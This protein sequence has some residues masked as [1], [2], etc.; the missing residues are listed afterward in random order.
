MRSVPLPNPRRTIQQVIMTTS[1]AKP[2]ILIPQDTMEVASTTPTVT[3][4][5]ISMN[6]SN[7]IYT[8]TILNSTMT[9]LIEL[10]K[11]HF[12]EATIA[13]ILDP[14]QPTTLDH[15]SSTTQ[16]GI[17]KIEIFVPVE[18]V[19]NVTRVLIFKVQ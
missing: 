13:I 12:P 2:M 4:H 9:I 6:K 19:P 1:L 8:M 7:K 10:T 16:D 18:I 3:I 14:I 5:N 15:I 11:T 17:K